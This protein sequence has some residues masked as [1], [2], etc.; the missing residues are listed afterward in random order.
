MRR[1]LLVS[2]LALVA[3]SG[4]STGIKQA[5]HTAVG[6]SARYYEVQSVSGQT[7]L[8]RFQTVGVEQFDTA[9]MRGVIPAPVPAKVQQAV[10]KQLAE[11]KMFTTVRAGAPGAG[12]LLIRGKF[13][14][15][16]PGGS[17]LR[18]VGFGVN[19]FLTAQ[20]ELVDTGAGKVLGVA[21]VT[22]TVKSAVRTGTDELADGVGKAVKGL[23]ER[24]HTKPQ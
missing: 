11:T 18:A 10:V 16:D 12:G 15:F 6:A 17:A 9:P 13:M 22:G 2:V 23:V 1:V 19:P 21:M 4:C 8:D 20:V 24:H 3:A 7:A 5:Y 14:D